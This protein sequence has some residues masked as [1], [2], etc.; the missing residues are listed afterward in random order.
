MG[1]LRKPRRRSRVSGSPAAYRGYIYGEGLFAKALG[2][3]QTG[4]S[5]PRESDAAS[6]RL[7]GWSVVD[8]GTTTPHRAGITTARDPGLVE[9]FVGIGRWTGKC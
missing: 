1:M 8:N 7:D 2:R 9:S 5:Y 3:A 4:N 6:F